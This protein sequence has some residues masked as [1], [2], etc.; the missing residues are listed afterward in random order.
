MQLMLSIQLLWLLQGTGEIKISK[1]STIRFIRESCFD[2]A[3]IEINNLHG[4]KVQCEIIDWGD[5]IAY[6][7]VR[8]LQP[9]EGTGFIG[10]FYVNSVG[11]KVEDE[12]S[13]IVDSPSLQKRRRKYILEAKR[14][15]DKK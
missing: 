15:K 8:N 6:V 14:T 12:G 1:E 3:R 4:K 2:L 11:L 13:R 9:K 7:Q 5:S 10:V